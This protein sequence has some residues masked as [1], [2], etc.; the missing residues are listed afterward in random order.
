LRWFLPDSLYQTNVEAQSLAKA[1]L[2][3][4]YVSAERSGPRETYPLGAWK[5]PTGVGPQGEHAPGVLYR[6][7]DAAVSERL[8]VEDTPPTLIRQA[9]A[10][11]QCFFPGAAI[12]VEP[13]R[14]ASLVT[15]GLRTRQDTDFHRPQN[16]GYGLTQIL[17]ILTAC[18]AAEPGDLVVVDSP[19]AHL[20]PA[21]QAQMARFLALTASTG[22]QILME[23]HSDHVLN[24]IRRAV[25][26]NEIRW[27]DATIHFFT[28]RGDQHE[29]TRAHVISPTLQPD[30]SLDSWPHGFF[31]QYEKDTSYFAGWSDETA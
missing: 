7:A 16:V 17:P 20:H 1:L 4:N 23:S 5:Q 31:D 13:V 22:V 18:L 12:A 15:L 9:E 2:R 3:L 14:N 19:E 6:H 28:D 27:E 10:W 24:G 25:K 30:G 26:Q 29:K 8:R 21:A 11:M